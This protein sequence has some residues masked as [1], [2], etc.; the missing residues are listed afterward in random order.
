[1]VVVVVIV[2]VVVRVVD[3][4]SSPA[5]G[6]EV[7]GRPYQSRGQDLGTALRVLAWLRVL[8]VGWLALCWLFAG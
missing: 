5:A 4:V 1:V 2:V 8:S 3:V 6:L 7:F